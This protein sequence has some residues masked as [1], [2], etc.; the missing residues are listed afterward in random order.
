V[1]LPRA[2]QATILGPAP[3]PLERLRGRYRWQI[4]VK[5]K[6]AKTL[7]SLIRPVLEPADRRGRSSE[8]RLC[9]DVDPYG[10]L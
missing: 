4:L 9:V 7:Q 10:M 2:R 8:V 6:D 3:A 5:G 1:R